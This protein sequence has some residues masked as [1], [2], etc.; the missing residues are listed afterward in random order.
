M[1]TNNPLLYLSHF[2]LPVSLS[3]VFT[4]PSLQSLAALRFSIRKLFFTFLL[5]HKDISTIIHQESFPLPQP[6]S[7]FRL[8]QRPDEQGNLVRT[9]LSPIPQYMDRDNI[10]HNHWFLIA[11]THKTGILEASIASEVLPL[12]KR[13][14]IRNGNHPLH[15]LPYPWHI[16]ITF[17]LDSQKLTDPWKPVG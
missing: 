16:T 7:Q 1:P 3:Y 6:F 5:V 14:A 8:R 2:D 15:L 10:T 11:Q 4:K 12:M 9:D 17:I 13:L